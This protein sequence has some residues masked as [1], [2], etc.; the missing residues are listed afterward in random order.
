MPNPYTIQ[1]TI[2]SNLNPW[3]SLVTGYLTFTLFHLPHSGSYFCL[4]PSS[5][6]QMRLKFLKASINRPLSTSPASSHTLSS[7]DLLFSHKGLPSIPQKDQNHSR[8]TISI[9]AVLSLPKNSSFLLLIWL[10]PL[11][12]STLF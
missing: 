7:L 8:F 3:A 2:I 6:S 11:H 1:G 10:I 9:L 4:N 5:T 12:S